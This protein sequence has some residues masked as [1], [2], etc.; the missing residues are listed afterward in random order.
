MGGLERVLPGAQ[1]AENSSC[2][3][4]NVT[5]TWT[6]KMASIMDPILPIVRIVGYWA[7]ILSSFG[8]PGMGKGDSQRQGI[9]FGCSAVTYLCSLALAVVHRSRQEF[10]GSAFSNPEVYNYTRRGLRRGLTRSMRCFQLLIM[11]IP[12]RVRCGAHL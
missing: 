6:S 2:R 9:L 8:G 1:L 4:N 5:S 7:I 10:Q 12:G 3:W 11:R